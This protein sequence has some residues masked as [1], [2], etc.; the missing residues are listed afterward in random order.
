M[1][2]VR[3][4]V[5]ILCCCY[6][7]SDMETDMDFEVDGTFAAEVLQVTAANLLSDIKTVCRT[8]QK[9]VDTVVTGIDNLIDKYLDFVKAKVNEKCSKFDGVI[10][11]Q[12]I[13]S[14]LHS[15]KGQSIFE[16]V[17][18]QTLLDSYLQDHSGG[19]KVVLKKVVLES[20][21]LFRKGIPRVIP[22]KFGYVV[23]FLAQ[24]EQLLNCK[25]VLDCAD[26]PIPNKEEVF[27]SVTDGLLYK[28]NDIV[29]QHGPQTLC[30]I[31]HVDDA[32]VCD[33][34][35]SKA[36]QHSLRLFYWVLGNIHPS[37]RSTLKAINLLA[38]VKS[39]VA[40]RLTATNLS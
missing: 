26:N 23:P 13:N 22:S 33:P 30:F 31:I 32:E 18:N 37:K 12:N 17:G 29:Q 34:L 15:L 3:V 25:D 9:T 40:K 11:L 27:R 35:K 28:H 7:A 6:P 8:T 36:G 2:L 1:L 5:P 20:K 38:I 21:L 14:V 19:G 4:G 24:L 10:S 16:G 39:K